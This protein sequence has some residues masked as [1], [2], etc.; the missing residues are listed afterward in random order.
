MNRRDVLTSF[1][2][3]EG[4]SRHPVADSGQPIEATIGRPTG[5]T[6]GQ[7]LQANSGQPPE[8]HISLATADHEEPTWEVRRK[9][10][11]RFDRR[12]RVILTAA[13]MAALLANAGAAW[14]YWRLNGPTEPF[15]GPRT[16]VEIA[17]SGSS[18]PSQAPRA[19]QTADLTVTVPNQH[20]VPI[21]ITSIARSTEPVIAD[22]AHREAGCV[23]PRVEVNQRV[24]PVSWEVQR[25]T[26]GAFVLTGALTLS[27]GSPEACRGATFSVPVHAQALVPAS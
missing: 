9:P 13:A 4:L 16:V 25:N 23:D 11:R 3:G 26:I 5:T 12:A 8:A 7:S 1:R 2:A 24:F 18:D 10:R 19:D 22:D 17:L 21:R 15:D 27:P 14:A 6:I 20:G